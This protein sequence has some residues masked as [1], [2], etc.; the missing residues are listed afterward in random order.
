[1]K[2]P[3]ITAESGRIPTAVLLSQRPL[4]GEISYR[5]LDWFGDAL[6]GHRDSAVLKA[7][8]KQD[9]KL[10]PTPWMTGLTAG[11]A[12]A[13]ERERREASAMQADL[14]LRAAALVA[15]HEMLGA[16]LPEMRTAVSSAQAMPFDDHPTTAGEANETP[17]HRT[18]RRKREQAAR[19]AQ[20][21]AHVSQASQRMNAI[22]AELGGL[23]EEYDFSE[24]SY[25]RRCEA[26][27]N[28][29]NKR[30]AVYV[31]HGLHRAVHDG[32]P[33]II[34]EMNVPL[35]EAEPFPTVT[36]GEKS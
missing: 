27:L 18:N 16:A 23:Q 28:F 8:L 3:Q 30:Q 26:L 7:V 15:E 6:A 32:R 13:I 21:E 24:L 31:R 1:M 29:Y 36:R 12:T 19:V 10:E 34:P 22:L 5:F 35:P 11:C 17:E 4:T 2:T 20:A 25:R 33:P 14:R 9:R